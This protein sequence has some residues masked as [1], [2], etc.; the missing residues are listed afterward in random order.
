MGTVRCKRQRIPGALLVLGTGTELTSLPLP[1]DVHKVN[2]CDSE[3]LREDLR[4]GPQHRSW[5]CAP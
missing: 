5:P 1:E 2:G 3:Q 4:S